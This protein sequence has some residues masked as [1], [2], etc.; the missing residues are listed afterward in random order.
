M[1]VKKPSSRVIVVGRYVFQLQMVHGCK[2]IQIQNKQI[3]GA[4]PFL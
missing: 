4:F 3:Q 2:L 1:T